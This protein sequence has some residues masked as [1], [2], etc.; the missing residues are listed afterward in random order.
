M[1]ASLALKKT[2]EN[3]SVYI[4]DEELIAGNRS[5][6]ILG[7]VLPVERG[8]M[9][10]VL[11]HY[12][13][14]LRRR[15]F[16]PFVISRAEERELRNDI[17]RYWEGRTVNDGKY[18][19]WKEHRLFKHAYLNP[20]A[21]L[22]IAAG[23]TKRL[24]GYTSLKD[25]SLGRV[26]ERSN[27]QIIMN[28]LD[29]QGHL[30]VGHKNLINKGLGAVKAEIEQ[31]IGKGRDKAGE[32]VLRAMARSIDA[33]ITYAHRLARHAMLLAGKEQDPGRKAQLERIGANC[34]WVPEHA[35]RDFYEAMQFLWLV[36]VVA[37]ISYGSGALFA[38]G[39][40]DQYLYPFYRQSIDNGTIT[41]DLAFGL[42]QELLIKLSY[43]LIVIPSVL[44]ASAS[45]LGADNQAVTVGGVDRSGNDATNELSS[46][47][48][49]AIAGLKS[50]TNSFSIRI[51][52]GAPQDF[53][54]RAI[55]V[56]QSTSGP[57]LFNDDAI[58]PSLVNDGY[59]QE[60]ARDYAIIGCVE[61]TSDGNTFA[62][63]S[64]NDISLAGVLELTLLNGKLG[65]TLNRLSPK[66]GPPSSFRSFDELKEA[67][68][69]HLGYN[70]DLMATGI[71]L[72]DQVYGEGYHDPFVSM[73][74]DGC[75]EHAMDMTQ[76]GAR[77]NFASITARGFAT[78]VNSLAAIRKL[79]FEEKKL[80]MKELLRILKRDFRGHDEL[81][82]LMSNK[83]PKFGRDDDGADDIAVWLHSTFCDLVKSHTGTRHDTF[84][85]G[86]FSY[87][88]HVFDGIVLGAT[89]DGRKAGEPVSN[90]LSPANGTETKGPTAAMKSVG[91]LDNL[92]SSNGSSLNMRLT[93]DLLSTREGLY[94]IAMLVRTYFSLG[95]MHVQFNVVSSDTL[96]EA[97][98]HPDQYK[99]LIVR[100]S[101]YTAYFVDLGRPVQDDIISRIEFGSSGM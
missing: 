22:S 59:T 44:K 11:K 61:P 21:L 30:V 58:I 76:G 94:K 38:I 67:F 83:S 80:T 90:S 32:E 79:V 34:T 71:D 15:P 43:N 2:L 99:D 28:I 54:T 26:L 65:I 98:K 16:R 101:G 78:T 88:I 13:G 10:A 36:Q 41:P 39:R 12:T 50:M 29:V 77:Y 75:I 5:S 97:Q 24:K 72:K 63:T 17:L 74:I 8:D 49:D 68:R 73:T 45:E 84:R 52:K 51:H 57:A 18:R 48:I 70:I 95:G 14:Q 35:P 4:M 3:M 42:I 82:N 56:Y 62:T 86:F 46:L 100:V 1:R 89:P 92:R 33:T 40:A 27:P 64:G 6:K 60:D 47:F 23:G 20:G 81:R 53:V 69:V 31:A 85:P 19:L 93:P 25:L 55:G 91:K 9:S 87:G 7:V 37:L 66:T 96:R